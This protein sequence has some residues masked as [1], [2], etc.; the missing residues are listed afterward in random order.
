MEPH[1]LWLRN[2]IMDDEHITFVLLTY[3]WV[4]RRNGTRRRKHRH[5][6]AD[7]SQSSS[8]TSAMDHSNH[9][10]HRIYIAYIYAK[11]SGTS[12]MC[13]RC[14]CGILNLAWCTSLNVRRLSCAARRCSAIYRQRFLASKHRDKILNHAL[15]FFSM[16]W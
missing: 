4:K 15:E 1:T 9:R 5:N 6:I 12:P 11:M 16:P 14:V 13:R 10:R 8:G 7:A 3:Y 2:E